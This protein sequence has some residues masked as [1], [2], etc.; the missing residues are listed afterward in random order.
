MAYFFVHLSTAIGLASNVIL[1]NPSKK[2]DEES[3]GGA[4]STHIVPTT[5]ETLRYAQGDMD[6]AL[7]GQSP[8]KIPV[9]LL[10][11]GDIMCSSA[12]SIPPGFASPQL[13]TVRFL[14]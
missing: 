4:G 14:E 7:L 8:F 9:S 13:S 3:V 6:S 10:V 5:S 11:L 2:D 1:R 12:F